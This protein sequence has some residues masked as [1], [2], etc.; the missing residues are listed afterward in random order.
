MPGIFKRHF[1]LGPESELRHESLSELFHENTKLRPLF[2]S[3]PATL[4][5]YTIPELNAMAHAYKRY[6]SRPRVPLPP[7]EQLP[8]TDTRFD[9]VIAARRS[10]RNFADADL[11]LDALARVLQQTYGITGEV[12]IPGGGALHFRAAPS[13]G[14]L[15]PAELYFGVRR[16]AGLEPGIYHYEVPENA[17]ALLRGGDQ[18]DALF[19]VCCRQ[20]YAR[21]AAVIVLISVVVERT[22]RKYGERGYRY[23][24]LD[25]G[26]LAQNLY[27]SATALGLAVMTT[28]GFFDDAAND[29]L[30]L[31]GL[32]EAVLYV[33]FI[34]RRASDADAPV[35]RT[36][37]VEG[38]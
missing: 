13:A 6:R 17:L 37:G 20:E 38:G 19:D 36:S 29:L 21:I 3:G 10:A 11:E 7:L 30:R 32:D 28:C 4:P 16:I 15:Y 26:H 9:D 33:A 5:E 31:D 23:A 35:V 34:G 8:A 14:A 1:A 27:L 22:K 12:R 18:T 24:L 2:G 25:V